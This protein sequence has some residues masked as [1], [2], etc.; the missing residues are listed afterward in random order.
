MGRHAFDAAVA[1]S[2]DGGEVDGG[3]AYRWAGLGNPLLS[4]SLS[5]G[6]DAAGP[7]SVGEQGRTV[8]IR[9]RERPSEPRRDGDPGPLAFQHVGDRVGR[10]SGGVALVARGRRSASGRGYPPRAPDVS[11][12]RPAPVGQRFD[13][14]CPCVVDLPGAG[15]TTV[16]AGSAPERSSLWPTRSTASSVVTGASTNSSVGRGRSCRS[17][18]GDGRT[19]VLAFQVTGGMA[20]GPGADAFWYDVGG[21]AGQ[22]EPITGLGLFGGRRLFFPVRG[23]EDGDRSGSR[24]WTASAEWRFPL[25]WAHRGWGLLP[26]HLDRMHGAVF[27]D[28]GNA[29]GPDLPVPGFAGPRR[30]ALA[31][32]GAEL[33]FD[34]LTFF[35]VPLRLRIGVAA[36]LVT[37]FGTA[38]VPAARTLLLTR[39]APP[40]GRGTRVAIIP[41]KTRIQV[42]YLRS[43]ARFVQG[44]RLPAD[45]P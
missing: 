21:A 34:A 29:W 15:R 16:R 40:C 32:V 35:T 4:A 11:A 3:V 42:A 43:C 6:W 9:E 13:R 17:G 1:V 41:N 7:F 24:A 18:V 14:A 38:R 12:R 31:S 28:A 20:G 45:H 44:C 36:P 23:F 30:D 22:V 26:L 19:H 39:G 5:Q 2:V 27:F 25:V 37:G 10:N 33:R 8:F